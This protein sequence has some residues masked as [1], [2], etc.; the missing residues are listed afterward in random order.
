M[1]T[2]QTESCL[3]GFRRETAK[4]GVIREG[5]IGPWSV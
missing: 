4:L 3:G 5:P 1:G 2:R